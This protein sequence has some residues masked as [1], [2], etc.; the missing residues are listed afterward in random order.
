MTVINFLTSND[1]QDEIRRIL[2]KKEKA[3]VAVAFWGNGAIKQTGI[4]NRPANSTRVLCDLFSGSCNPNE[5]NALVVAGIEV[6]SLDGMH[7]KIWCVGNETVIGSA[8]ASAN[9]LG[10]E[11][12]ELNANVEACVLVSDAT[13]AETARAWFEKQ[14]K[15]PSALPVGNQEIKDARKLWEARRNRRH[16]QTTMTLLEALSNIPPGEQNYIFRNVRV[17]SYLAENPSQN[18]KKEYN[19]KGKPTYTER[20]LSVYPDSIP[21]YEDHTGWNIDPGSVIIDFCCLQ[22]T[23]TPIFDGIWQVRSDPFLPIPNGN[24]ARLILC[25][26]LI[27]VAGYRFPKVEQNIFSEKIKNYLDQNGWTRDYYGDYLDK[28][29]VEFWEAAA[30]L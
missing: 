19:S 23:A 24:G 18:A 14:W 20:D 8:N 9:G 22:K 27:D 10:F 30:D 1:I 12:A 3:A 21:Y 6:R 25:D 2:K 4:C 16:R 28:P 29:L 5:I 7:A 13:F 17:I 26:P 15:N 11:G